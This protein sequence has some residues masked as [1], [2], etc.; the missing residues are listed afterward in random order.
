MRSR[1]TSRARG[2]P[3]LRYVSLRAR[4]VDVEITP[5]DPKT[6][7]RDAWARYHAFRRARHA[8][9][10]P[11]DPIASDEKEELAMKRDDPEGDQ[12]LY[13]AVEPAT[14]VLIGGLWMGVLKE[15]APSYT[16]NGHIAWLDVS[17]LGSHRRNGIGTALLR[18]VPELCR[19]RGIR[20]LM[21]WVM[22]EDGKSFARAV[23]AKIGSRRRENRLDLDRLDW[24]MVEGWARAGP[25]Q[26]PGSRLRWFDG[27]IDDGVLNDYANVYTELMNQQPRDDLDTGDF[28]RDAAWFRDRADRF[29]SLGETWWTLASVE[30]SGSVSGLTEVIYEP[31]EPDRLYQGLTGVRE[32]QRGRGLG[33]W[34]KAE[35]LLRVRRELPG[36]RIVS[37][38]N[39]TTNDA[40]L[41]IN[42]RLGFREHRVSEMPQ[43]TVEALEGW[44]DRADAAARGNASPTTA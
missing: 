2:P 38:W 24:P 15:T 9:H 3:S 14:G 8:E 22:E 30:P 31:E 4:S 20:L 34:L 36:V 27:R 35:M 39:A 10:S 7:S 13:G 1:S 41:A 25:A 6:A 21:G 17:V 26:S 19:E 18:L 40:M 23:G 16:T 37:T 5:F 28:V 44:L 32:G 12:F 43:M 11:E 29:A 42:E 33:K